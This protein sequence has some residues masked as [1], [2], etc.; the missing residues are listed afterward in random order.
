MNYHDDSIQVRGDR[1]ALAEEMASVDFDYDAADR[2][3]PLAAV[4]HE[5]DFSAYRD[6]ARKSM[7]F[8]RRVFM[9]IQDFR[10]DKAFAN[11]CAMLALGWFDLARARTQQELANRHMCERANVN[12]LVN[13]FQA[14]LDITPLIGQRTETSRAKFSEARKKQ[15]KP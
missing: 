5:D 10:G 7:D 12:R 9:V 8:Y 6:A 3:N 14:L 11:D 15:L 1:N 4:V 2:G 13:K